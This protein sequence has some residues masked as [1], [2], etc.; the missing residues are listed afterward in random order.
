[1]AQLASRWGPREKLLLAELV[2]SAASF[3]WGSVS[4]LAASL[5]DP[6]INTT[7]QVV[8]PPPTRPLSLVEGM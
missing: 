3:D 2:Q 4:T 6:T 5:L 7:E 8:S 1:M